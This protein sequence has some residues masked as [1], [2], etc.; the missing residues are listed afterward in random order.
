[1]ADL[2]ADEFKDVLL[3]AYE[4]VFDGK[5][6]ERHGN[7]NPLYSQPWFSISNAVGN[8]FLTGQSIK[9]TMEAAQMAGTD[10][11]SAQRFERELL[12]AIAYLA[13][14]IMHRR[15]LDRESDEPAQSS[16]EHR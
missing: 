11:Y 12:G 6:N 8:G 10:G 1:M 15:S 16:A 7:G 14:A 13:F 9:K 4:Q 5:G 3:S 2:G